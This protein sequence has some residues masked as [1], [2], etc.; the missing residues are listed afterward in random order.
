MLEL[1]DVDILYFIL[2]CHKM[3]KQFHIYY[4]YKIKEET[5]KKYLLP[6]ILFEIF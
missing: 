4:I 3:C 5:T 6:K 2:T 1:D